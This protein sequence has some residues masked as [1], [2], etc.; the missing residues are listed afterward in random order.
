MG[1]SRPSSPSSSST[2]RA[3]TRLRKLADDEAVR[4]FALRALADRKTELDGVE[5]SPFI[6][7]LADASP[8]VRAQAL[9][10]SGAW[11]TSRRRHSIIPLTARPEGS[12]MPTTRPVQA[13]PDPDRV[14]PHLAVRALVKLRAVDACLEAIDGPHREG[15]SAPCGPCTSRRPSKG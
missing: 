4:E 1:G 12:P 11:A 15:P 8:R 13:Q 6:A 9:I 5:P 10:A 2:A 3:R 7:A 14:V